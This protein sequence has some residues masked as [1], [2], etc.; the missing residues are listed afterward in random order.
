M[1]KAD[2]LCVYI[3]TYMNEVHYNVWQTEEEEEEEGTI[4]FLF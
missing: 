4:L 1:K 3:Y 2:T